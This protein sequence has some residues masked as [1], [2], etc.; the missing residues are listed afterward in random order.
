MKGAKRTVIA[1]V[2]AT[3]VVLT[4]KP[5][6]N[7]A[8]LIMRA[9]G[10]AGV[11]GTIARSNARTV[12]DAVEQIQIPHASSDRMRVRIFQP[13]G[14]PLG[15]A[16]LVTGVHPDGINEPRLV[17]LA[18]ELAATGVIVVTPEIE[19]L[20]NYRVTARATDMVEH[21]ALWMVGRSDRFGAAPIGL[22]GVSFSGGLSIVAAGRPALRDRVAYV[23]SFGGHGNLPRV[24]RYLCTGVEPAFGEASPRTRPPHDYALAVLAH[25]TADLAVPAA[26]VAPLRQAIETFLRASAMH[27]TSLSEAVALFEQA[28]ARQAGLS[29]PAQTLMKFVNDRD[30]ASLGRLLLPLV[31]RLEYDV[32]LSPDRSRAPSAPV[33]LLHGVDDNVI[34]H[35][36]SAL[37]AQHLR[38]HTRVRLLLSRYLT[39]VDLAARP[40]LEDTWTMIAFW[41]AVLDE[42]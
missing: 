8:T 11:P 41:K 25:Q 36:E 7:A 4:V 21:A 26:Q 16:L 38:A 6:W 29:E 22:I 35:V 20:I 42:Y 19:D 5:Y 12:T 31:D 33:Y 28:R 23:L 34:P 18:R 27:R 3:L 37:L 14:E 13:D 32:S 1:L 2:V 15:S 30:V 40:T 10:T 17:T 24:L 9:A 39:H